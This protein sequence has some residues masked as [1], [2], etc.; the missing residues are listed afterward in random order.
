MVNSGARQR[1]ATPEESASSIRA[2]A[3]VRPGSADRT[4]LPFG[5]CSPAQSPCS[6]ESRLILAA[7]RDRKSGQPDPVSRRH[8]PRSLRRV[9]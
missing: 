5:R 6:L 1:R 3:H 4:N 8:Q 2:P 9:A 7:S